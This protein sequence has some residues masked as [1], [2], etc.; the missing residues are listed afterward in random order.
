MTFEGYVDEN[1]KL[2]A[3]PISYGTESRDETDR[4]RADIT[5]DVIMFWQ[6]KVTYFHSSHPTLSKVQL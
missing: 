6:L 4:R 1:Q 5:L 3:H 2:D